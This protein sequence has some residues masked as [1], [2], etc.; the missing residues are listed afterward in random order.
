MHVERNYGL[1]L[2]RI[3][4]CIGVLTYHIMDDVLGK[5]G[6]GVRRSFLFFSFVLCAGILFT[7]RFFVWKQG[8]TDS[9]IC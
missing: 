6:G 8:N 5:S 3:F 4:C 9:R 7:F 2:Y 1:D